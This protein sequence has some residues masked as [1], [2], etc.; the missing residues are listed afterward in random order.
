[1]ATLK[2][3]GFVLTIPVDI[4]QSVTVVSN[5]PLT[6]L[7]FERLA[8]FLAL[9]EEASRDSEDSSEESSNV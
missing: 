2:A 5:K 1:M 4:D 6:P 9:A 3:S 8:Q 7:H